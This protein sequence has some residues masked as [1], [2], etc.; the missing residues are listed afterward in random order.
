[1][2]KLLSGILGP[3]S[4]RIGNVVGSSWKGISYI[5]SYVIP[6]NPNTLAQQDE[7]S[8]FLSIVRLGKAI[9]GSVIQ[10]FWDPF[11][12]NNSGW[13]HFIGINRGLMTVYTDLSPLHLAEGTLEGDTISGATYAGSTVTFTWPGTPLGNGQAT[14]VAVAVVYDFSHQVAFVNTSAQRSA[15]TVGVNVGSG[16]IPAAMHAWLFFSDHATSPTVVSFSDYSA[17]S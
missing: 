7:R 5:R 10:V 8:Q 2:A 17:V 11:V 14:D 16:R 15:G 4:G 13:A 3:V 12:N 6:G 9:L 1:M